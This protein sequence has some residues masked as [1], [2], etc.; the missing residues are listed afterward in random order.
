MGEI[1]DVVLGDELL[2]RAGERGVRVALFRGDGAFR[3]RLRAVVL[4]QLRAVERRAGPEVPID[5]ERVAAE[6]R[7]PE[8]AR[9]HRDTRGD[10]DHLFDAF[11]GARLR[12]IERLDGAAEHG[13]ARDERGPQPREADVDPEPGLPNDLLR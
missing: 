13:R 1:G 9:D 11:D 10:L 7:A 12:R 2:R 3:L 6:L 8:V 5:L 4:E